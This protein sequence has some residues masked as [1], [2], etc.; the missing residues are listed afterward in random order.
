MFNFNKRF[1][2]HDDIVILKKMGLLFGLDKG[3]CTEEDIEKVK[4]MV[5]K[6]LESYVEQMGRGVKNTLSDI[7]NQEDIEDIGE[8]EDTIEG[9]PEG[10][11]QEAEANE[12][13]EDSSDVDV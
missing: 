10:D 13:S 3:E 2:I 4:S 11:E 6:S 9:E 8:E 7:L 5:P 12:F 1:Q